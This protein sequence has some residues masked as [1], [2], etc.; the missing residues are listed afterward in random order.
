MDRNNRREI[1]I[2]QAKETVKVLSD[3]FY[4]VNDTKVDLYEF[5]SK[6]A[7]NIKIKSLHESNIKEIDVLVP[8]MEGINLQFSK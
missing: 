2:K 8:N 3:G 5:T 4:V 1:N 7:N 6:F